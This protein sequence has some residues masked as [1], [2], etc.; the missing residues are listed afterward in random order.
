M[1]YDLRLGV[2]VEGTDIIAV[3]DEPE[4][5]SPTYN[6]GKMFRACMNWDFKQGEWYRVKDVLPNIERGLKELRFNGKAYEKFNDP[7]G[8][9]TVSS[10][11]EALDSLIQCISENTSGDKWQEIPIEHLWVTW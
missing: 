4:F 7:G 10:A 2:K 1:S 8:W 11:I 9:G 6:L 3:I 5:S